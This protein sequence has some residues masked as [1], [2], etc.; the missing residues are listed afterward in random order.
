MNKALWLLYEVRER[1]MSIERRNWYYSTGVPPPLGYPPVVRARSRSRDRLPQS[2]SPACAES[3]GS[4]PERSAA[5][6][7]SSG[8]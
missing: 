7:S 4:S 8:S 2:L 1:F 6:S 5:A 3:A